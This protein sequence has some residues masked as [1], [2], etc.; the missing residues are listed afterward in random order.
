MDD[1]ERTAEEAPSGTAMGRRAF[2]RR[3]LLVAGGYGH[4]RMRELAFGGVTRTLF[5]DADM[6]VLFSH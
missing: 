1:V 5:D 3:A 2:F 6:P 4:R